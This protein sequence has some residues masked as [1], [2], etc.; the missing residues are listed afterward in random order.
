MGLDTRS[1]RR[2]SRPA[3]AV[4]IAQ[5]FHP[6]AGPTIDARGSR[7]GARAAQVRSHTRP[8]LRGDGGQARLLA[9]GHRGRGTAR[10][11]A[12]RLPGQ[13]PRAL[14][15]SAMSAS[16]AGNESP[17]VSS[18]M[19]GESRRSAASTTRRMDRARPHAPTPAAAAASRKWS[20]SRSETRPLIARAGI[21]E[22]GCHPCREAGA[23]ASHLRSGTLP[24]AASMS[25][26][27]PRTGSGTGGRWREMC[28]SP[29]TL[30]T[31]G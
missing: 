5:R 18:A 24:E 21:A 11:R 12:R 14:R 9:D 28:R 4:E 26:T 13:P 3:P 17:R 29:T 20:R 25:G 2:H 23:L 1:A 27:R 30:G 15:R 10:E 19:P 16:F 6:S 7:A 22:D 8:G 31:L